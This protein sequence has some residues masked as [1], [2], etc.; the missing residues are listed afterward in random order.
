M[1]RAPVYDRLTGS[2]RVCIE[3]PFTQVMLGAPKYARSSR[4]FLPCCYHRRRLG[5]TVYSLM[6]RASKYAPKYAP[7]NRRLLSHARST[8]VYT[9]QMY[10]R[11][12]S[13][14][15]RLQRS[16]RLLSRALSIEVCTEQPFTQTCSEHREYAWINRFS[17][18]SG[19]TLVNFLSLFCFLF[20]L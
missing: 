3:Q 14:H 8:E 19:R 7:N 11:S 17:I 20:Q 12:Y 5:S 6:L 10:T 16:N 4:F 1:H 15:R 9:E 2:I 18:M 13:E